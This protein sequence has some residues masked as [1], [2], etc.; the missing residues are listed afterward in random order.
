MTTA[1]RYL[2][3]TKKGAQN[4]AEEENLIFRLIR[5]DNENFLGYPEEVYDGR[6]CVEIENGKVVKA[7]FQ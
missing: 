2:G 6:V 4:K 5:I 7:T 1:D 3:L